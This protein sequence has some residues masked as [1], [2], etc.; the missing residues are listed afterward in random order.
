MEL[1]V[2]TSFW[3]PPSDSNGYSTATFPPPE[4]PT[5]PTHPPARPAQAPP[6]PLLPHAAAR[7]HPPRGRRTAAGL[8]RRLHAA[9][10][11]ALRRPAAGRYPH[12]RLPHHPQPAAHRR[13]LGPR[14]PFQLPPRLLPPP[15]LAV[16][17][18][19]G[20]GRLHPEPVGPDRRRRRGRRRYRRRAPWQEGL[21]QGAAP[22]RRAL[23]PFLY[24]FP[25]GAQV[26]GLGRPGPLPLPQPLVGLAG[27]ARAVSLRGRGP[28]TGAAAQD[29]PGIAAAIVG[30]VV[31]LVPPA[32]LRL[33]R[34]RQLRH[35]RA[36]AARQPP[37]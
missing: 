27:L 35:P 18:R 17:P 2:L 24:R 12:H 34:R 14:P 13:P 8:P 15:L 10:L 33:C 31:S 20:L 4:S 16:A 3:F 11:R 25:L 23:D 22:R 21:R 28:P 36:V 5:I 6:T 30:R 7:S 29:A 1:E 19:P 32:A 37:H 9:D 26:G